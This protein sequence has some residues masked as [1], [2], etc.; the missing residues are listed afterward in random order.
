MSFDHVGGIEK[1][2]KNL[3]IKYSQGV[4]RLNNVACSVN[5]ISR[6]NNCIYGHENKVRN[7]TGRTIFI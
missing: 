7:N 6:E 4:I 3:T 5:D 1:A 2:K